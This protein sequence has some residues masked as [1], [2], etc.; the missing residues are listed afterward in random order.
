[1]ISVQECGPIILLVAFFGLVAWLCY[2]IHSVSRA[3]NALERIADAHERIADAM[4]AQDEDEGEDD[5]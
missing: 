5:E 1:M 3:A 2:N 4:E